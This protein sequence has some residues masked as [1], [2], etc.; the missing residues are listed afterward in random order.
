ML[1]RR[2]GGPLRQR[3]VSQP[4]VFLSP[5]CVRA[6]LCELHLRPHEVFLCCLRVFEFNFGNFAFARSFF[7]STCAPLLPRRNTPSFTLLFCAMPRHMITKQK[8]QCLPHHHRIVDL[9]EAKGWKGSRA[10][11]LGMIFVMAT[12]QDNEGVLKVRIGQAKLCTCTSYLHCV[13]QKLSRSRVTPSPRARGA[14][15][16]LVRNLR[17]VVQY[18]TVQR[19]DVRPPRAYPFPTS[20]EVFLVP[21][22]SWRQA[23][24]RSVCGP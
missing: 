12:R 22:V 7:K 16:V 8:P 5:T 20:P 2:M 18:V 15:K 23:P 24:Q 6:P 17:F 21:L 13:L 3:I 11:Y 1:R 19:E 9:M 14:L 4:V 10:A